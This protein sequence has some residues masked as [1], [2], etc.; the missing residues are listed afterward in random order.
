M[1]KINQINV[2]F[3]FLALVIGIGLSTNS[4]AKEDGAPSGN[5]GS[6]GDDNQTCAHVDCHTGSA[7]EKDGLIFTD[8]PETG[9]LAGIDY[10]VTVTIT[11]T[12]VQKFGFQ[13][14][15]QTI[16]GSKLGDLSLIN[17]LHT[18]MTGG[19][20]YVTH[21]LSGTSGDGERTWT[22]NWTPDDAHGDVTFYVAV[23]ASD[24]EED[25]TGDKIYTSSVTIKEDP[26]NNPLTLEELNRITF[27]MVSPAQEQLSLYIATPVNSP[28]FVNIFDINGTLI[29]RTN[30]SNSNGAFV[31]PLTDLSSGLY[32]VSVVN[33]K[34]SLTKQFI[35]F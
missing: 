3:F 2:F 4:F 6:P 18:K 15:P 28:I 23:N 34:G 7:S 13:A 21:T 9:Y 12:A 29:S 24:N 11:D 25:A 19:S 14:S 27:D 22:F 26:A 31:I 16:T 8:V 17:T 10:L 20:K 30:F 32:F 35:K 33:E 1:K 5:T